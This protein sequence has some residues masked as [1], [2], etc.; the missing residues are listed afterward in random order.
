MV[1]LHRLDGSQF[2]LNADLIEMV[3]ATP[4]TVLRLTSGKIL[5]VRETVDQV[6]HRVVAYKRAVFE[7]LGYAMG[8]LPSRWTTADQAEGQT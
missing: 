7:G 2:V 4:D 5:V 6:L 1:K 3:E 8:V